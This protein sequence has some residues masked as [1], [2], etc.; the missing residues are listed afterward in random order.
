MWQA[1]P[2]LCS[3]L[4]VLPRASLARTF[5]ARLA[6]VAQLRVPPH[7]IPTIP[8]YKRAMQYMCPNRKEKESPGP[9]PN[10]WVYCPCPARANVKAVG[11]NVSER[12][13]KSK[14]LLTGEGTERAN[15]LESSISHSSP[16]PQHSLQSGDLHHSGS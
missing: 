3:L 11:L 1:F 15:A 9:S 6:R 14:R 13:T 12:Y 4:D 7:H 10:P 2:T 8:H 16:P 5:R